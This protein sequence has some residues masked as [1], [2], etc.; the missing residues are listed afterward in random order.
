MTLSLYRI[1]CIS[2]L[3][4]WTSCDAD[5]E[6]P[7]AYIQV[8]PFEFEI[9]PGE[10]TARQQ[11]SDAWIYIDNQY[12]GAYQ[13]PATLPVIGNGLL[14]ILIQPGYR[15]NGQITHPARYDLLEPY[16]SS[17]LFDPL[18]TTHIVPKTAYQSGLKFTFLEEFEG[19]HFLNIDRDGNSETKI[20]LSTVEE[21]FEGLRSGVIELTNERKSLLAVY[22]IEKQ[23]PQSPDAIILELHF[24]SDIPFS[25]GFIGNKGALGEDYLINATLL[26]KKNWTKAYF[27]FRDIINDSNANSYRLAI[28][29]NYRSD[30]A[31]AVQR[32]LLDNIKVIHR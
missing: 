24:K 32:I 17:A 18:E 15:E 3:W 20:L 5:Q 22:D 28:S 12:I 2:S 27:N 14:E 13:L 29:A 11:I 19:I 23:I 7:P 25:I 10:G 30:T 8:N 9:K 1:L 21:A 26:P 6:P 4:I 16:V 31:I